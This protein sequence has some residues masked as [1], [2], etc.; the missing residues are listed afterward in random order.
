MICCENVVEVAPLKKETFLSL[1][2]S[3]FFPFSSRFILLLFFPFHMASYPKP[4]S[5][6]HPK[7]QH[8]LHASEQ[9]LTFNL[10]L[11]P[12]NSYQVRPTSIQ[13]T[14][15]FNLTSKSII[16]IRKSKIHNPISNIHTNHYGLKEKGNDDAHEVRRHWVMVEIGAASPWFANNG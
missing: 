16:T 15:T 9:I 11:T 8:D 12:S 7:M 5:Y 4:T 6:L 3:T 13:S 10:T 2:F 14:S 1:F